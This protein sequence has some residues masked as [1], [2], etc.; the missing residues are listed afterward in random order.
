MEY[1]ILKFYQDEK[2]KNPEIE[3]GFDRFEPKLKK[4]VIG[5]FIVM[6]ASCIEMLIMVFLS[7]KQLWYF[8]GMFFLH[9]GAVC[10]L[11]YR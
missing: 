4:I 11:E 7:Q 2:K 8:I 10:D 3:Q 6:F 5:C 9:C 1:Y